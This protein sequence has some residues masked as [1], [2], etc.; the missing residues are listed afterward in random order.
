[1]R[2][3]LVLALC[4]TASVFAQLGDKPGETQAD[5]IPLEKVPP[6]TI[7]SPEESL[8]TFQLPPGFKIELVAAEPLIEAP[9]AM[10]WHP[11]GSLYV[12]E[13]RGFMPNV[14]GSGEDKIPGR[15]KILT[16]TNGDGRMD[17]ATIFADNLIMPRALALVRD[18]LL[19][20][21]PPNLWFFRGT[22]NDGKADEKT[23]AV[24]PYG[25][26]SNPEHTANG[27]LWGRDNWLYSANYTNRI[28]Y[29]E[30]K[31]ITEPSAAIAGRGQWEISQDDLGRFVFNSNSDYLR[32]D[33]V[34]SELLARNPNFRTLYGLNVQLDR[35]QATFPGRMNT[36]VNRG[37]TKG[38]LR[39]DGTL[40]TFTAAC[41]AHLYRGDQFDPGYY[42]MAFVCEPSGNFVRASRIFETNAVRTGSNAF[43]DS[44]FLTSTEERFRPV[45]L[46]DGPDGALYIVDLHRGILQHKIYVTSY[47]RN[48]I[49]KRG[50]QN[51]TDQ[52]R[53][54]RVVQENR[55]RRNIEPLPKNPEQL[56]GQ[57]QHQN[58]WN[59]ETAQRLL[60]E[61]GASAIIE[62][63]KK[64]V[65][66]DQSP[67]AGMHA[68]WTLHGLSKLDSE[69]LLSALASKNSNT[70]ISATR[71]AAERASESPIRAA[72]LKSADDLDTMVQLYA[73]FALG[74][75]TE[76]EAAA[77]ALL[78]IL[79]KH[80]EENLYHAAAIS[81]LDAS[82]R[83]FASV[84]L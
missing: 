16:D 76:D 19:V 67:T 26:Q 28:R 62:P 14:E 15:V 56:V 83:R 78:K 72:L 50:L 55:P 74:P 49:E 79:E 5:P 39:A 27:L 33:L 61:S 25:S 47:L 40:A 8:K 63:L 65:A 20:A 59:R 37:Y 69:T 36:G 51:P 41:S 31:W 64:L 73:A 12:L 44:E 2:I 84:V 18:G 9:V 68:L 66:L 10:A 23:L 57:L 77:H 6:A 1:M 70:R 17:Q 13:L 54:Y 32:G 75:L 24:D 34:P 46:Y 53:I 60:V 71:I 48:Q 82:A 35:N 22:N 42:G 4:A 38:Q 3:L 7:L 58:A 21:E 52:G 45:N 29:I 81:G 30:G 43:P 11:N 80:P